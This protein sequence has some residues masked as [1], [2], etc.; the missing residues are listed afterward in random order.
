[1]TRTRKPPTMRAADEPGYVEISDALDAVAAAIVR[2]GNN[3]LLPIYE[4]LERELNKLDAG[5]A[6]LAR[7]LKRSKRKGRK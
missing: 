3:R 4:R 2:T 5:D 7:A 6:V 1:M